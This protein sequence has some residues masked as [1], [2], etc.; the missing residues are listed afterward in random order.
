M[1][2]L[3]IGLAASLASTHALAQSTIYKHID[4]SGRVTYTNRPMKGAV[5]IDLEPLST[6]E[7]FAA[8]AGSQR[9]VVAKAPVAAIA[10]ADVAVV[11]PRLL[12]TSVASIDRA[13][14]PQEDVRRKI[15]QN[16][17]SE[18]EKGLEEARKALLQ[19]QRNPALVAAVRAAQQAT[20]P[21]PS[22]QA[23]MRASIDRA[24][25]RIRGLQASVSE[26][27]KKIE[28]LNKE[29]GSLKP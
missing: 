3:W 20:D 24:S 15:L 27:E 5:V 14:P 12:P 9:G 17:L 1:K 18:V 11:T 22:Q 2:A 28:A 13:P 4:E 29:L 26:H 23:E 19:E 16:E 25:G 21:T 10:A 6:I 7:N 8:Q